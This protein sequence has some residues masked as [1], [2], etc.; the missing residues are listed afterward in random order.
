PRYWQWPYWNLD[1]VSWLS[2]TNLGSASYIKTNAYYNTFQNLLSSYN[3]RTYTSQPRNPQDFDSYYDDFAY[4]GFI[5]VGTK[6]IPMNTL[7]GAIHFRHDNH[8]ERSDIAPDGANIHEPWQKNI[9]NTW[10]FALENTFH[11]TKRLDVVTGVSYDVNDVKRA[12][13]YN[14][15]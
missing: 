1:S 6:L 13:D 4:G 8:A 15:T 10:S 12:Q 14:A 2:K 11:A 9:E 3:N 7:K 5:V